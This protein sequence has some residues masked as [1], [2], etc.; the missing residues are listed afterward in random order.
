MV[1]RPPWSVLALVILALACGCEDEE[2]L[3]ACEIHYLVRD[4]TFTWCY[5]NQWVEVCSDDGEI[6]YPGSTCPDVGYP[7]YCDSVYR[8]SASECD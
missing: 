6:F 5:P 8:R 3:G 1:D 4:V 2:T 7:V